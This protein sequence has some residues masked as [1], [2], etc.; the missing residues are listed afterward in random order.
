VYEASNNGNQFVGDAQLNVLPA[1]DKRYMAYA[2]DQKISIAQTDTRN[3]VVKRYSVHT[4][5]VL[6]TD[7]VHEYTARFTVKSTQIEPRDVVVEVPIQGD[8]WKLIPNASHSDLGK[9]ATHYRRKITVNPLETLQAEVRQEN[10]AT[11]TQ[12]LSDLDVDSLR[13]VLSGVNQA[14]LNP[15]SRPIIEAVIG[16]MSQRDG[17][18][19]QR[20]LLEEALQSGRDNQKRIRDNLKSVPVNSEPHSRYM[21]EL[22]T[23]DAVYAKQAAELSSVQTKQRAGAAAMQAYL[24]GVK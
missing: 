23:A 12:L 11:S 18:E 2:V 13:N 19:T 9:T 14:E 7:Y 21:T 5:G 16:L 24:N 4:G 20:A 22:N 6:H 17:L 1:N 15:K 8:G 3:S 10:I